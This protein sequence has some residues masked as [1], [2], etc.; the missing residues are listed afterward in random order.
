VY[1]RKP[2]LYDIF[3]NPITP[4]LTA[5]GAGANLLFRRP[6]MRAIEAAG[7]AMDRFRRGEMLMLMPN[8][9]VR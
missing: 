2:S 8:V 3:A 9:F 1:P 5:A 7:A 6:E 4:G